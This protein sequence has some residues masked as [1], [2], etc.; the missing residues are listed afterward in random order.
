MR[1]AGPGRA[2][3]LTLLCGPMRCGKSEEV[4]R[5][6]RA[7]CF[8]RP[9]ALFLPL[10]DTR[11]DAPAVAPRRGRPAHA[12]RVVRCA[13]LPPEP[14]PEPL[15][16]VDEA[17]LFGDVAP[18]RAWVLAGRDVLVAGLDS[19]RDGRAY[20]WV[21][22]VLPLAASVRKL[23]AR[24]VRCGRPATMTGMLDP[25]GRPVNGLVGPDGA[26]ATIV[27]DDGYYPAC[28]ACWC[29]AHGEPRR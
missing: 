13:A 5:V 25:D 23:T 18:V 28:P 14:P 15:A 8:A 1:P 19:D 17:N 7:E 4:Q 20:P 29:A 3:E 10:A 24:C 22:E 11:G 27:G 6:V 16:V 21:A 12:A 9:V 2:G 26:A